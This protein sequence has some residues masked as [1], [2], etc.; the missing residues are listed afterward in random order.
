MWLVGRT[1]STQIRQERYSVISWR[2]QSKAA[3]QVKMM[4]FANKTVKCKSKK[5]DDVAKNLPRDQMLSTEESAVDFLV[6]EVVTNSHA[7]TEMST[8]ANHAPMS[9][10]EVESL[11]TQANKTDFIS[12]TDIQRT[13]S[14][15]NHSD[16]VDNNFDEWEL[17]DTIEL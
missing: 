8:S 7:G 14:K 6:P 1:L 10:M 16:S 9:E 13:S 17:L 4:G 5:S 2:V 15:L 11:R 12:P 3:L